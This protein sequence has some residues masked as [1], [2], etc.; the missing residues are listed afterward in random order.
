MQDPHLPGAGERELQRVARRRHVGGLLARQY[1]APVPH[2]AARDAHAVHRAAEVDRDARE[3]NIT[4]YT[5]DIIKAKKQ[6]R[7]V[8]DKN[9]KFE[10][11]MP[12]RRIKF[13]H[14]SGKRQPKK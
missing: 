13:W 9:T 14:F 7:K 12:E 4:N 6:Y 10:D 5:H 3:S 1:E 8:Y 11:I 2:R